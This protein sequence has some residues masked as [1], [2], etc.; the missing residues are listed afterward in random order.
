MIAFTGTSEPSPDLYK[1][2]HENGIQCILGTLG[3]LDKSA[4]AK[5]DQLYNKFILNGADILATDRPL[6][7]S[8]AYS[9]RS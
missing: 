8:K 9:K 2:L 1:M 7:A 4:N 5:G 6:E 3:N